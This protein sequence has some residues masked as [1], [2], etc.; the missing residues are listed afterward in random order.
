[1]TDQQVIEAAYRRVFLNLEHVVVVCATQ[2]QVKARVGLMKEHLENVEG[3]VGDGNSIRFYPSRTKKQASCDFITGGEL[4][5]RMVGTELNA[6]YLRTE[7]SPEDWPI[8]LTRCPGGVV[9]LSEE[10]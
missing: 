6:V 3:W 1:M 8:I 5:T 10:D 4:R 9:R 7:V 2:R